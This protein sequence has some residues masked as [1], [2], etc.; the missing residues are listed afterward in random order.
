MTNDHPKSL[1]T[2]VVPNQ[3]YNILFD[4]RSEDSIYSTSILRVILVYLT[5]G[6][7]KR[8]QRVKWA[9]RNSVENEI[10]RPSRPSM[11]IPNFYVSS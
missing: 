6:G 7:H 8:S 1:M 3:P 4:L 11:V 5:H 9:S 10:E 2:V